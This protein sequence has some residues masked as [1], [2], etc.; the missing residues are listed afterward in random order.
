MESE[1]DL[2][3]WEASV[4]GRAHPEAPVQPEVGAPRQGLRPPGAR[5]QAISCPSSTFHDGKKKQGKRH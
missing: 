4:G 5:R 1:Q 2:P 3:E